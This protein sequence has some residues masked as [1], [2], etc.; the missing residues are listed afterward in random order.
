MKLSTQHCKTACLTLINVHLLLSLV[1][2]QFFSD[3]L[4]RQKYYTEFMKAK[5]SQKVTK[6]LAS[7]SDTG[8]NGKTLEIHGRKTE[9][10]CLWSIEGLVSLHTVQSLGLHYDV[11]MTEFE[12]FF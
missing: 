7:W 6:L 1:R 10:V 8:E 4:L 3:I 5:Y 2:F 9:V 11:N 12:L